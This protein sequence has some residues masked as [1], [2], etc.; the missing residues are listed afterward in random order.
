MKTKIEVV[1]NNKTKIIEVEG[2]DGVAVAKDLNDSSKQVIAIGTGS[3]AIVV[4]RY[5]VTGVFPY[6]E[7]VVAVDEGIVE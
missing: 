6:V 3:S 5:S 7:E 2:Y 4:N 1:T